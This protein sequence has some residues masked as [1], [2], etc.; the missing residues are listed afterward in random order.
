MEDFPKTFSHFKYLKQ[1]IESY[2][3][4]KKLQK[5]ESTILKKHANALEDEIKDD[6]EKDCSK[7]KD[8][9]GGPFESKKEIFEKA[10]APIEGFKVVKE[11]KLKFNIFNGVMNLNVP[12]DIVNNKIFCLK[13]MNL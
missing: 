9:I 8:W 3:E 2:L 7:L 5:F 13:S 11:D 10:M 6:P 4:T 1:E 12:D